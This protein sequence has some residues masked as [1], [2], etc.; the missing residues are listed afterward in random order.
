MPR[1]PALDAFVQP[2][3][4]H[5]RRR[6]RRDRRGTRRVR[7]L[8]GPL[9]VHH[10]TRPQTAAVPRR[11]VRRRPSRPRLPEQ[12]LDGRRA[13]E[14]KLYLAGASDAAIV[15]GLI[16]LLLRVYSGRP[17]RG[18]HRHRPGVPERP[19]AAGGALHQ[20]RQRH[21]RHGAQGP[22]GRRAGGRARLEH[23][24]CRRNCRK[25]ELCSQTKS[26]STIRA[27]ASADHAL[28]VTGPAVQTAEVT[29][30]KGS[31]PRSEA[32]ACLGGG[33][34][35]SAA[36]LPLAIMHFANTEAECR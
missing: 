17:P 29:D 36:R 12:G 3:G 28:G 2:A 16:A 4:T 5:R 19:R 25:R 27:S 7:R 26:W 14:G 32:G 6:D 31:P 8:D 15:S 10:R 30:C 23:D 33:R 34:G 24:R 11:M 1:M 9:P 22:R 21:R 18:N 20:P 35:G 13:R